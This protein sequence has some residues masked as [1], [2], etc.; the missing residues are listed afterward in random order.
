MK[1]LLALILTLALAAAFVACGDDDGGSTPTPTPSPSATASA[2]ETTTPSP[3][4]VV[5]NV[6]GVNPDPA[7]DA[8]LT[9]TAPLEGDSVSSPVTI[10]G[11]A[12]Q[13][14]GR[15]WFHAYNGDGNDIFDQG[16]STNFGHLDEPFEESIE[17][18]VAAETPACLEVYL[19]RPAEGG[20][21]DVVQ[22]PVLLLPAE[23][24]TAAPT[25]TPA[26]I[27]D[28]CPDNPDPATANEVNIDGPEPGD[29]VTSPFTVNG[30]AAAFEAVIQVTLLDD[31][32]NPLYDEPGMTNE[33]QTLAPFEESVDFSVDAET[34]G[35]LQVYTLSANDGSPMNIAQIPLVLL[36]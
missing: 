18:S 17:F 30:T 32:G 11:E 34:D 13:F 36:P 4:N 15:V 27:T 31:G 22:V 33:G 2:D 10:S 5:E 24:T 16:G 29:M 26:E 35:C 3:T 19:L 7:T 23:D 21:T 9:V 28:V 12:P 25:P 20:V 1:T 14:E 8:D 6:C